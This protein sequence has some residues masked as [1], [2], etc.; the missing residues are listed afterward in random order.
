[1]DQSMHVAAKTYQV[2]KTLRLTRIDGILLLLLLFMGMVLMTGNEETVTLVKPK[3]ML[4]FSEM[5]S[6]A[7][8]SGRFAAWI[9]DG[10][11]KSCGVEISFPESGENRKWT[12]TDQISPKDWRGWRYLEVDLENRSEGKVELEI[13]LRRV[14]GSNKNGER[15]SFL[16]KMEPFQRV[17]WRLPIFH[18]PYSY[19]GWEWLIPGDVPNFWGNGQMDLEGVREIEW[20]FK[21]AP[22]HA[23]I[24]FYGMRFAEAAPVKGWVDEFGQNSHGTWPSK[25]YSEEELRAWDRR[26]VMELEQ[27]PQ[28]QDRD[29]YQAWTGGGRHEGTG[30]FRTKKIDGR[31]WL[32][33]P[34]GNLF[35]SSGID[36][37]LPG[38]YAPLTNLTRPAYTSL[39][40]KDGIFEECWEEIQRKDGTFDGVSFY[41]ANLARK[42]GEGY[43]KKFND[44]A[45]KRQI[46]WGFTTIGNWSAIDQYRAKK[47][48][49]VTMGTG[50]WYFPH[51]PV[52]FP[53]VTH[54][55]EDVFD[56]SFERNALMVAKET[57]TPFRD[58]PWCIGHFLNN[59]LDWG[60]FPEM[61]LELP[62]TREAKQ[63]ALGRLKE[64]Y[65]TVEA[66]QTA[67]HLKVTSFDKIYWPKKPHS[68]AVKDMA[69]IRGE[70]ADLWY[71]KWTKAYH[72]ADPNHLVLGSRIHQI[73]EYV[74]V[75]EACGKHV[76]VVSF[77]HYEVVP[78]VG[79]F[80]KLAAKIDK[81]FLIGEYSHN[82]L[83]TGLLTTAVPVRDQRD[84]ATG[85]RLYTEQLAARPYFVGCHYFQFQDE[86]ITG[87][88]DT[89]T[90][91]NGF[92]SVADV[93]N[94][95]L[96]QAARATHA[97]IYDLHAGKI[98]PFDQKPVR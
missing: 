57:L 74:E 44:R 21:E 15:V 24:G 96:V 11:G 25:V 7:S 92:V 68:N 64:K 13:Y 76:D 82:S 86:P 18:I 36:C 72:Q 30:F 38:I 67:W 47:I 1:M 34:N 70:Y 87:R 10:R 26:E 98:P 53:M 42:W 33:A 85:F 31:W 23:A 28:M 4:T 88:S 66:L 79:E 54:K 95:F 2:P 48:P 63:W 91:Y 94:P 69:E 14:P 81:P 90:A 62:N 27:M 59:E 83:D 12:L 73:G 89:E 71:G 17:V 52:E 55:I 37:V 39:P 22:A 93:P 50:N 6:L 61:I 58:D 20:S 51:T 8:A 46:S 60:A 40:P 97:R 75:I 29:K 65:G 35:F 80:D 3:E 77:N 84:R 41:R 5:K 49:Y 78:K 43:L 32:V 9:V 45:L 56:P 16:A 19:S